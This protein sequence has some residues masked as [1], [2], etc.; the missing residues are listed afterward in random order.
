MSIFAPSFLPPLLLL[1]HPVLVGCSNMQFSVGNAS[2]ASKEI[3]AAAAFPHVRLF[4]ASR[5]YNRNSEAA[6]QQARGPPYWSAVARHTADDWLTVSTSSTTADARTAG[7]AW[8]S[9]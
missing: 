7:A 9:R 6:P 4:T 2:N 5:H 8:A 1:S 3:A